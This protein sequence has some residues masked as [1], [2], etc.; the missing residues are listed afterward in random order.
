MKTELITS[1]SLKYS[2]IYAWLFSRNAYLRCGHSLDYSAFAEV[3]SKKSEQPGER[4][5]HDQNSLSKVYTWRGLLQQ[6]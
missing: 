6:K 3:V 1:S 5:G 4:D 2:T